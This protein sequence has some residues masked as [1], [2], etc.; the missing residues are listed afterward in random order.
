[1]CLNY[2]Y[3]F[4]TCPIYLTYPV[5]IY[6]GFVFFI[7]LYLLIKFHGASKTFI[8]P[9]PSCRSQI[10]EAGNS[11]CQMSPPNSSPSVTSSLAV[12]GITG[13][14]ICAS[15]HF[16]FVRASMHL[17]FCTS[18]C[19]ADSAKIQN[20]ATSPVIHL[21]PQFSFNPDGCPVRTPHCPACEP[22][23]PL[24]NASILMEPKIWHNLD[25]LLSVLKLRKN[26]WSRLKNQIA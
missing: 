9:H 1:M 12:Q 23:D 11:V 24:L 17:R 6:P 19:S 3:L 14:R 21:L 7:L 4:T 26:K 16:K 18:M 20:T 2:V 8:I 15:M 10:A 22:I 13:L 25:T 5:H